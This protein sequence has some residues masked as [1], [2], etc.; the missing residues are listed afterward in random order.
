MCYNEPE[1]GSR[2][3]GS[4]IFHH[5]GP[6]RFYLVFVISPTAMSFCP[7]P[8]RL[9]VTLLIKPLRDYTWDQSWTFLIAHRSC[10]FWPWQPQ[11]LHS[12]PFFYLLM[13]PSTLVSFEVY[14]HNRLLPASWTLYRLTFLYEHS[15]SIF[16]WQSLSHSSVLNLNFTSSGKAS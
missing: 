10:M 3:I 9:N 16:G 8:A 6:S 7:L 1:W 11:R 14:K 15:L 12:R 5:L 2:S 13:I 4:Q